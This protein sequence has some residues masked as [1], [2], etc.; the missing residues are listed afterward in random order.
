MEHAIA[1]LEQ[2]MKHLQR[3]VDLAHT[4]SVQKFTAIRQKREEVI[5]K[6]DWAIERGIARLEEVESRVDK[7]EEKETDDT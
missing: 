5:Q 1:R 7:L 2:Q 6:L 4:Q 3:Q